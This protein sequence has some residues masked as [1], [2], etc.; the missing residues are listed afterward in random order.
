MRKGNCHEKDVKLLHY[1]RDG[2]D[3]FP[4]E[5]SLMMNR[6]IMKSIIKEPGYDFGPTKIIIFVVVLI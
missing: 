1:P 6:S 3:S 2:N 5:S 4:S